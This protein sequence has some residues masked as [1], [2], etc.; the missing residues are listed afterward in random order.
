VTKSPTTRKSSK[1][2]KKSNEDDNVVVV[3]CASGAKGKSRRTSCSEGES[4]V[5]TGTG[6]FCY[7]DNIFVLACLFIFRFCTNYC[8]NV[9]TV[10][11]TI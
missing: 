7:F 3:S 9:F 8:I 6:K 5:A 1:K 4:T 2:E 10:L 11:I